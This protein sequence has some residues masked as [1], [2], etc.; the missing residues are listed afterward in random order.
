MCVVMLTKTILIFTSKFKKKTTIF[1]ASQQ[2]FGTSYSVRVLVINDP[3][4]AFLGYWIRGVHLM[5]T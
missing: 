2:M 3:T 4:L 5:E 1:S